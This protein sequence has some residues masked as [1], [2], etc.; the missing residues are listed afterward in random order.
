MGRARNWSRRAARYA[1]ISSA[2]LAVKR[3]KADWPIIVANMVA[4]GA[5]ASPEETQ[6]ISDYLTANFGD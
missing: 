6:T 3:R 1:T 2:S 5:T 4:R